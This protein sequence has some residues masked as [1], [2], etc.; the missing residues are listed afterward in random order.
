VPSPRPL[1]RPLLLAALVA[2]AAVAGCSTG[3]FGSGASDLGSSLRGGF[4][5][6]TD[7]NGTQRRMDVNGISTRPVTPTITNR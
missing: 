3:D 2:G 7:S 5:R 1:P 6:N 4:T